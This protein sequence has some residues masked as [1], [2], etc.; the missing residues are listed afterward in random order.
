AYNTAQVKEQVQNNLI[1][2]TGLPYLISKG[3]EIDFI[4]ISPQMWGSGWWDI[5]FV[6]AVFDHCKKTYGFTHCFGHGISAGGQGI[7]KYAE[8]Y[9]DLLATV[10]NA[11]VRSSEPKNRIDIPHWDLS[12]SGDTT[13]NALNNGISYV[14]DL[15]NAGGKAFY[16]WF[17][18]SGHWASFWNA[19]LDGSIKAEQLITGI[20]DSRKE[21]INSHFPIGDWFKSL[22]ADVKLPEPEKPTES[23]NLTPSKITGSHKNPEIMFKASSLSEQPKDA[24][25]I[26]WNDNKWWI[27]A[28]FPEPVEI[29][30]INY[31][32]AHGMGKFQLSVDNGNPITLDLGQYLVWRKVNLN[33]IGQSILIE[34]NT[35]V[36]PVR[37]I[38][39]GKG[40][41]TFYNL[42]VT[43]ATE[44][45]KNQIVKIVGDKATWNK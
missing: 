35:T 22:I 36:V 28:E 29:E 33:T 3:F 10:S 12:N 14:R 21:Y 34:G 30:S 6:K 2:K 38:I 42:T 5:G 1:N 11:G 40:S 45:E 39:T 4:V 32:D 13:V 20:T 37:I 8:R 19:T 31:Y 17:K 7:L 24:Y 23:M 15:N 41:G 16:T 43:G 9:D 27:K 44:D 18:G 26:G 25:F